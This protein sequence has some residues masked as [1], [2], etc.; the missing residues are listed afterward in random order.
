MFQLLNAWIRS[1]KKGAP[2]SELTELRAPMCTLPPYI[3]SYIA[4]TAFH[5]RPQRSD[6]L[7]R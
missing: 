1:L 6:T 3:C 4:T 5:V 2:N 7:T